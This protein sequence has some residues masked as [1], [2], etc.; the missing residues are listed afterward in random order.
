MPV[1]VARRAADRLDE[2]ARRA[3]EA[4]LVR[5]EDRDQRD[6][7]QVE[8]LAQ[9][10]DADQHVELAL[11]QVA[12]DAHAL[13]RLDVGVQVAHAH[14]E[15]VVV[16]GQVLGHALGER[17]DQHA[18]VARRRAARISSSRS[19]TWPFTGRTSHPRVD[20]AGRPDD[21]LDHHA[22][23]PSAARRA[24]ASPRRRSP[25]RTRSSNSSKLSGR[26]SS[27]DGRRKPY[28]TSVFLRAR[29]PRYIPRTCGTV[30]WL[31]STMISASF[32]QVVEQRRRRLARLRGP[33]GG[34]SSSRCRGSSRP[35]AASRG[36]TSCA[37][38][39]AA[40]RAACPRRS[41]SALRS[42]QLGLDRLDRVVQARPRRDVV[43]GRVDRDL[44]ERG[45]ASCRS[46]GRTPRST[47]PR[48]RRTR[49]ACRVSS[50]AGHDLDHVAAHAEG[51]ALEVVVVA[52]VAHLDQ[53]APGARAGRAS[54]PWRTKSSIP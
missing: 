33:R 38:R 53:L 50:Y 20:E 25:G 14:A 48:R 3:Q 49:C 5:V 24:R 13:E 17:R 7:G 41:S 37:A 40:P 54:S 45:R 11:A 32:G 6:L 34:A 30:W 23:R 35:R 1:D 19:S 22:A 28:S 18:L 2:R 51:A 31:S 44:R 47:R 36:R 46:A 12:Q 9:Q 26:L 42:M 39:A 21:L 15:V 29:S 10:V 27:A 16:L 8:P 52:L 4:F 43:A